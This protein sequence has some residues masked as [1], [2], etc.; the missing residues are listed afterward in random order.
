MVFSLQAVAASNWRPIDQVRNLI[1]LIPDGCPPDLVTLARWHRN[2]PLA[3]DPLLSGQVRTHAANSLITD[4]AAA[5]TALASGV[6][7]AT[8]SIG[9]SAPAA[10]RPYGGRERAAL[11]PLPTLMEAARRSGR[12]TGLVVSCGLS[13]ATP[14][15]FAAHSASRKSEPD[16]LEQMVH[17]E[18]DVVLGGG[19]DL[20]R[21]TS[22]GGTRVDGADLYAVLAARG[23]QVVETAAALDQAA[24]G[25]VWGLFAPDSLTPILDRGHQ[26]STEP[27]LAAM[28]RKAIALL[29]Q[30]PE[31]FVLM[32]EGSQ[33]DWGCHA[34]D[35]AYALHEFL[36][37]DAAVAEALRF[38]TGDGRGSTWVVAC[39]D[40]ETGGLT[41]GNPRTG[42]RGRTRESVLGPLMGMRATSASL[43][44]RV[45]T[46]TTPATIAAQVRAWW[47]IDLQPEALAD[48]ASLLGQGL[49][50]G[51]AMG[52][53]VSR[54]AT[55]LGWSTHD[56]TGADVPLWSFG[57]GRPTGL[58]DNA[59][60][61]RAAAQAL[62]FDMRALAT[63]LFVDLSNAFPD[64][65]LDRTDPA[66]P[67]ARVG[68]AALPVNQDL[69]IDNGATQRLDGVTILIEPTGKVYVT[70]RTVKRLH[71]R[72]TATAGAR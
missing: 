62:G 67:V 28:T 15:A 53:V 8:G 5:A 27:T 33:I 60:L 48:L 10:E 64:V 13:E 49:P 42:Y 32:V 31:G 14:A 16:L 54:H 37:F 34:N 44:T 4:S 43:H 58:V 26:P 3:V 65:Q 72:A 9:V 59:E 70:Q 20:M 71:A 17:Q 22:Q 55:D 30:A 11:A 51:F 29:R 35:A 18:L 56:H 6:K 7:T 52:E 45:G 25:R 69:L 19:R 40:H 24:T 47:D 1:I 61:G 39:A 21:P 50:A 46:N 23:Y 57:P 68:T 36:D 66:N 2:G 12:A 63:E 41:I 38:A